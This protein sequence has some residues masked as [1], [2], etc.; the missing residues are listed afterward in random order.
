[1][2]ERRSVARRVGRVTTLIL[3]VA[4]ATA[5]RAQDEAAS[6]RQ[7]LDR[8]KQLNDTT[9]DWDDLTRR[10]K[11]VIYDQRG[12]ER[13]RDLLMRT[14]RGENREDKTVVVFQD[15]PTVRGTA[16]LQFDHRDRDAEQWLYLPELR[17]VR[18]I[19]SQSKNE[20]FMGT[21]FS[22]RDLELLNDVVEWNEDEA[23]SRLI[24][25]DTIEGK[26]VSRI[27][28]VPVVKDVGYE[29]IVA[30]FTTD[31]VVLRKM[32]FYGEGDEPEK[33]LHL[34]RIEVV[35]GIPT[36]RSLRMEQPPE[37]TRTEVAISE[38]RY[39]QELPDRLFTER[40]LQRG[41]DD[42]SE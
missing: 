31:D 15:P 2:G 1:M 28:R 40:A 16:F 42:D 32:E 29:R 37:G 5:A 41:L 27:E 14:R 30:S 36:A 9:R 6:A 22:Y 17:R 10:M 3:A 13:N 39:N 26:P 12:G 8:V 35:D 7:I 4:L 38:V 25:T 23:R 19:T 11:I 34:D 20:S 33:V 18:K 21:D 24:G